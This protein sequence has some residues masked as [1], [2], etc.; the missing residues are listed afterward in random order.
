MHAIYA[1]VM[2]ACLR[3]LAR[4]AIAIVGRSSVVAIGR[5][6]GGQAGHKPN[7]SASTFTF[8]R[9]QLL[10]VFTTRGDRETAGKQKKKIAVVRNDGGD[11]R[12]RLATIHRIIPHGGGK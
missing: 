12:Y 2:F 7:R 4:F 5:S 3:F 8:S 6:A 11:R 10:P 1:C 9:V